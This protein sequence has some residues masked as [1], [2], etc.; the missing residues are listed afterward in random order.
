M[1]R[2]TNTSKDRAVSI[3]LTAETHTAAQAIARAAS[4]RTSDI[5]RMA[6][7]AGMPLTKTKLSA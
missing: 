2:K 4:L 6:I 5:L 3:R 1:K 7:D